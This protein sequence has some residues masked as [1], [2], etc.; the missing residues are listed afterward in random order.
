MRKIKPLLRITIAM[1]IFTAISC[2]DNNEPIPTLDTENPTRPT[3]LV[4]GPAPLSGITLSWTAAN[5]NTGVDHYEVERC[6]GTS[7]SNFASIGHVAESSFTDTN[8]ALG[9]AYSYRVRAVDAAG[10]KSTWSDMVIINFIQEPPAIRARSCSQADVELAINNASDGDIVIIPNGR[11]TWNKPLTIS[12]Q[13]R[14]KGESKGGVQLI[15]GAGIDAWNIS[16]IS[17]TTGADY[18]T[19]LSQIEFWPGGGKGS[20]I[21]IEG[22]VTDRPPIIHD[23]KF[24]ADGSFFEVIRY[25][26]YGGGLIYKNVFQSL[27]TNNAQVPISGIQVKDN[28]SGALS[29]STPSSMGMDD[30][31][32]L[33]NI[34]IEDNLFINCSSYDSDD[35]SRIVFRHNVLNNAIMASHGAD[36]SWIGM[37]HVEIYNNQ[38]IFTPSG[39][40]T[41]NDIDGNPVEGLYPLNIV[42]WYDFRGGTGVITDNDIPDILSQGWGDK[43]ELVMQIQQSDRDAGPDGCA[44]TY[45]A[46]HQ[47]GRGINNTLEPVY[48]W[49]NRGTG[50]EFPNIENSSYNQ[51]PDNPNS[52]NPAYY[53]QENRDYYVGVS[54]P[55]YQK[56]TYPHPLRD[57]TKE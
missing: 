46:F 30:V 25:L 18:S 1:V 24:T 52:A 32:G 6:E 13:I 44:D 19:V 54:K 23:N 26:R 9:K 10:N 21:T 22:P 29:W 2:S 28:S 41:L 42:R 45:P 38:F 39:T 37:R 11:C 47:V 57:E 35:G 20:Y 27:S 36:T 15:M 50:N 31:D 5:D 56:Y 4:P 43:S 12:K 53:I 48:I 7:C 40:W 33:Q 17:V 3:N 16:M 51:C 14:L 55:G 8:I 49:N 34:Y